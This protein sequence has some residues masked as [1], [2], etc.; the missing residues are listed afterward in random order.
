MTYQHGTPLVGACRSITRTCIHGQ[1]LIQLC[2][3]IDC[4][5]SFAFSFHLFESPL[6]LP[7]IQV[8][9]SQGE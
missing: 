4:W 1:Q 9:Q 7:D 3:F 6:L 5:I 8:W 2:S